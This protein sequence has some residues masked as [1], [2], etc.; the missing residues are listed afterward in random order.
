MDLTAR[1][2]FAI[3]LL[4]ATET[5]AE[6]FFPPELPREPKGLTWMKILPTKATKVVVGRDGEEALPL[7]FIGSEKERNGDRWLL[8]QAK[9]K[10]QIAS[11]DL[12]WADA[13]NLFDGTS[14]I[15]ISFD[16]HAYMRLK[17][18]GRE[19]GS[20]ER[21][22]RSIALICDDKV[23]GACEFDVLVFGQRDSQVFFPVG[24]EP[25][26]LQAAVETIRC[27]SPRGVIQ[28]ARGARTTPV[29]I[30]LCATG[31]G[32]TMTALEMQFEDGS[33]TML[34]GE[35]SLL[36]DGSKQRLKIPTGRGRPTRL[37]FK[38][39]VYP[40]QETSLRVVVEAFAVD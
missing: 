13:S 2:P 21:D 23:I 38:H 25:S 36:A 20:S 4:P 10:W 27:R 8:I 14:G 5:R 16:P 37:Q 24:L 12:L 29:A 33:W 7:N 9:D 17:D 35:L 1:G 30:N 11:P 32:L 31:A 40:P 19:H 22:P 34:D 28:F 26:E 6:R 15:S 3:R 39:N 18:M